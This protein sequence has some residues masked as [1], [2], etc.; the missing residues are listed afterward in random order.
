MKEVQMNHPETAYLGNTEMELDT[1]TTFCK[2]NQLE[3]IGIFGTENQI[4]YIH[5]VFDG[6][7]AITRYIG[8]GHYDK[9]YERKDIDNPGNLKEYG[10]NF[11]DHFSGIYLRFENGTIAMGN[12]INMK[13]HACNI[14]V[15]R[16]HAYSK[17]FNEISERFYIMLTGIG[18]YGNINS[19]L[20][21]KVSLNYNKEDQERVRNALLKL[22]QEIEFLKIRLS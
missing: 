3:K 8:Y 6:G 5:A 21:T 12:Q 1:H 7:R 22:K 15:K 10:S 4:G 11:T 17:N 14:C 20:L 2:G 18:I 19:L 13:T 16:I 9:N